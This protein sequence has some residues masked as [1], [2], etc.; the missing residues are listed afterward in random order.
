MVIVA[1][2]LVLAFFLRY[3]ILNPVHDALGLWLVS[4]ICEIWFAFS[5]ILDQFPKWFPIDRETYLDRLSFRYIIFT[6]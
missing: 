1:R 5:W 3:R 2:L 4:V 6:C